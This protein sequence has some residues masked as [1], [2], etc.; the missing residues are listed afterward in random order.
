MGKNISISTYMSVRSQ[1]FCLIAALSL[2]TIGCEKP[3][4][5]PATPEIGFKSV[6]F[7]RGNSGFDE[8]LITINFQDGDG[9][10]GLSGFESDPKYDELIF[11]RNS[12]NNLILFG[13]PE[14]PTEFN[15]CDFAINPTVDEVLIEDTVHIELNPNHNNIEV[16]FMLKR[17]GTYEEFD[18]RRAFGPNSC[19]S[20]DG[21]FPLL[22]SEDFDRPLEGELEYKMVGSGFL[23]FL[24][25]DT[26]QLRVLIRDRALNQSNIVS[27]NDFVLNDIV[28][29]G[30]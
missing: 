30:D 22:N 28:V 13:D 18:F 17:G 20:F 12:T 25:N 4:E 8:L 26:L 10:L 14:A 1:I 7:K 2:V 3:P 15:A 9:D 23:P 16:D 21:R 27:S 6:V 11:P 24:G 19:E 5:F 29:G